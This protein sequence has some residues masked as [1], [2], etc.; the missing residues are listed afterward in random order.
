M[1][2]TTGRK[3]LI[4]VWL[5]L[6]GLIALIV[7]IKIADRAVDHA[8]TV[9]AQKG[10]DRSRLLVPLPIEQIGAIEIATG[11]T[12]HRF[13]RDPA[14][15]WFYH[16]A[17]APAQGTHGHNTDP[18]M[19]A[20]IDKAFTGFGR[21][22]MERDFPFDSKRTDYGVTS[23]Q[24]LILLYKKGEMQPLV[25]YAIGDVAAD[26]VSR[27]ALQLGGNKVFTLPGFHVQ[28]LLTLVAAVSAPASTTA[29]TATTGTAGIPLR[30]PEKADGTVTGSEAALRA[31]RALREPT[32]GK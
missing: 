25:Q 20:R 12:V 2:I 1:S 9:V 8:E 4:A 17:H 24:T 5:V 27:Y 6:A 11:G 7:A 3:Q 13:E 10:G 21:A 26:T 18:E 30:P 22:K 28:N 31:L 16:S 15:A 32:P 14:G 29:T 23:P 19:A